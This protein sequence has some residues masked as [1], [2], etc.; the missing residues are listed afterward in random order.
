MKDDELSNMFKIVDALFRIV[1]EQTAASERI[2]LEEAYEQ[3]W[4]L[5]ERGFVRLAG[6]SDHDSLGVEPCI[7]R[8]ERRA[9]AAQN[10]WLASYR[11]RAAVA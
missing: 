7:G 1:A 5:Y 2:P 4:S 3:A 10:R 8:G 6:G 9:A 11:R